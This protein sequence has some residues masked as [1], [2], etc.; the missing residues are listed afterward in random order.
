[1]TLLQREQLP[2]YVGRSRRSSHVQFPVASG[3]SFAELNP[4]GAT[5][6]RTA[7]L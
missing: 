2:I 1:M 3:L 5:F 7:A 6:L 4:V